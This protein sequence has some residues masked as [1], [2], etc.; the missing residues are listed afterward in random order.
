[1]KL[2][3]DL[4]LAVGVRWDDALAGRVADAERYDKA[5]SAAMTRLNRRAM[6]TKQIVQKLSHLGH[7]EL[8]VGRV[9]D[10]LTELSVLDDEALGGSLIRA[11]NARRPAGPR[12]L[13]AKLHQRGIPQAIVDRLLA[14]ADADPAH[15]IAR[16]LELARKKHRALDPQLHP[17][18]RARRLWGLLARR[19]F[20]AETIRDALQQLGVSP[21][22]QGDAPEP[23]GVE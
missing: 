23:F 14:V 17:A 6:S 12:L 19:G 18:T 5:L 15:A 22:S 4:G 9:I 8:V 7:D 21:A 10:R 3:A 1:M 2:I 16:A 13:R 20:E 11:A